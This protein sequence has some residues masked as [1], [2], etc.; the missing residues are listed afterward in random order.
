MKIYIYKNTLYFSFFSFDEV[1]YH[2][3][4]ALIEINQIL[5][6]Y[7]LNYTLIDPCSGNSFHTFIFNLIFNK[8]IIT[9]DIQPEEKAWTNTI[10][11][12]GIE[13]IENN[14]KNFSDKILLLAWSDYDEFSYKVLSKFDWNL[15]ISIGNYDISNSKKYLKELNENFNL[16]VH[17]H[18][19]MPW[20]LIEN[21]KIYKKKN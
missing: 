2:L 14:V 10:S 19:M 5:E 8:N 12:D 4:N 16:I 7:I 3:F 20:N 11:S 13:Y 1:K 18:L 17:Y 6:S 21:V 15:V 9:I